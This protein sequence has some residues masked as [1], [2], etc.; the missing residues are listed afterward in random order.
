MIKKEND[1]KAVALQY[2]HLRD[3]APRVTAK[4]TGETARKIIELARKHNIPLRNDPDLVEVLSMMNLEEEIPPAIY[5][6]VAEL[7]VYIY[8]LNE[9]NK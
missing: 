6:V 9:D 7:L 4:G 2:K 8:R 3:N 5:I 1:D